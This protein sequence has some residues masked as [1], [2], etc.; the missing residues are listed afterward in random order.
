MKEDLNLLLGTGKSG[1]EEINSRT[2]PVKLLDFRKRK[3]CTCLQVERS[4]NLHR[5]ASAFSAEHVK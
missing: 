5:P 1:P 2:Y 4:N 3:K